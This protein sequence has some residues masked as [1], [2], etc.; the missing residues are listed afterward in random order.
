[1]TDGRA[2]R[3]PGD[4]LLAGITVLD[5]SQHLSGPY[6]TQILADLGAR[7]VKVEPP[8]GDPTRT[9]GPHFHD[10]V[11]AYF[12]AVNRN[13]ESVCIDLKRDEGRA[14][15]LQMARRCDVVVE[16]FRPGT[17][18]RLGIGFDVL[19]AVN[20]SVVLCS[21]T[22]FGQDG[23]YRDRPAFDIIVQALSGAMSVTGEPGG[24]P[25][26]SGVPIGDVCTGMY[27]VIGVLAAL[28]GRHGDPAARHIDVAMLDTQ[29]SMLSYVAAYYLI[30]GE[31]AGPQG[32][33]HLSFPTYRSWRCRDGRE[34]V[35]AANTEKQW[36][37]LCSALGEEALVG[38]PRFSTNEGR[39][40]HRGE[41]DAI[42]E[43][44]FA[45][46]EL[47]VL[48][49][50]LRDAGV[51]SAPINPIDEALRDPQVEFRE[52]VVELG[53]NGPSVVGNPVWVDGSRLAA[54]APPRLGEH[55]VS[56]LEEWREPGGASVEALL[57]SGVIR[58]PEGAQDPATDT[59]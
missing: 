6:A 49:A 23:P 1:M 9:I 45:R 47:D 2:G 15:L 20:P 21:I 36:A 52:M 18:E 17:L 8:S 10:G 5:L 56:V 27:G 28:I 59:P 55:T 29:L 26:R 46:S 12:L 48:A 42:L 19:K 38:D 4:G 35:T 25:V 54:E 34:I 32:S 33:A 3:G 44:A 16:N 58:S 37:G 24:S 43:S 30:G 39:R 22:G 57:E 13:K 50:A 14:A 7:V 51:P 31:V 41:L 53:A 11:S 40:M